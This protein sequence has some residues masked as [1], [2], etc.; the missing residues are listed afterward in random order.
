MVGPESPRSG[1]PMWD[2]LVSCCTH[3]PFLSFAQNHA[4]VHAARV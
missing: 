1:L 2:M 3:A 4:A